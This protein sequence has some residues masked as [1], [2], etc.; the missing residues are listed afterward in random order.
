MTWLCSFENGV[1]QV[2]GEVK[3][4]AGGRYPIFCLRMRWF[5]T[6][7]LQPWTGGLSPGLGENLGV[8]PWTGGV[9]GD[10]T[11]TSPT[12]IASVA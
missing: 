1:R 4:C 5:A 6:Q 9:A 11:H 8:D 3:C 7:T 12:R 10:F 2:E